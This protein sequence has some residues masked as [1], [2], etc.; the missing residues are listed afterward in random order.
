MPGLLCGCFLA[1]YWAAWADALP[2]LRA[3]YPR[4]RCR[5]CA[6][7]RGRA[8]GLACEQQHLPRIGSLKQAGK[9]DRLG[10]L[11]PVAQAVRPSTENSGSEPRLAATGRSRTPHFLVRTRA[12]T[13]I[14][15]GRSSPSSLSVGPACGDVAGGDPFGCCLHPH[16]RPHACNHTPSAQQ[17]IAR[18]RVTDKTLHQR[19]LCRGR[20]QGRWGTLDAKPEQGAKE[21]RARVVFQRPLQTSAA[22]P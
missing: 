15:S 9:L 17:A 6:R 11:G 4:S 1:A 13:N 10:T 18:C 5:A 3:R 8:G 7:A 19:P 2:V 16:A 21:L 12:A 22:S 20:A 14:D